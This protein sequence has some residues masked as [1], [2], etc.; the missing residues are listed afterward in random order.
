MEALGYPTA[1]VDV[2]LYGGE[3][4]V[5][6]RRPLPALDAAIRQRADTL[7]VR[8]TFANAR[9][10]YNYL[11][12]LAKRILSGPLRARYRIEKTI[13]QPDG[14]GV[15]VLTPDASRARK[16]LRQEYGPAVIVVEPGP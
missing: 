5:V 11:A 4:L 3:Q 10:S 12:D 13:T 16:P 6:Y 9:Y 1:I 7:G 8:V 15:Q 2:L 14:S